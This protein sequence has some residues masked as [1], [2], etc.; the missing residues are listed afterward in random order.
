MF[1]S[2]ESLAHL[3]SPPS[4]WR[5]LNLARRGRAKDGHQPVWPTPTMWSL[6]GRGEVL[7]E[8]GRD[9]ILA[10]QGPLRG[11]RTAQ[12]GWKTSSASLGKGW[13]TRMNQRIF[14]SASYSK[15]RSS[16]FGARRIHQVLLKC[17]DLCMESQYHQPPVL[18]KDARLVNSA[19]ATAC[20]S[21]QDLT[22]PRLPGSVSPSF[23]RRL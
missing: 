15:F 3:L 6:K 23:R 11:H 10:D 12:L 13:G 16:L 1:S 5:S 17:R 4:L 19:P 8:T 7:P 22:R 9:E 20:P 18:R 2:G 14:S 21:V